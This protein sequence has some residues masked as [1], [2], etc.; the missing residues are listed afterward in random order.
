MKKSMH[1][2]ETGNTGR[3]FLKMYA[4]VL[5]VWGHYRW[6]C[7]WSDIYHHGPSPILLFINVLLNVH[8]LELL[9]KHTIP[10]VF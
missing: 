3:K 8:I 7:T 10:H 2:K 5:S 4:V 9:T 6:Y 1:R